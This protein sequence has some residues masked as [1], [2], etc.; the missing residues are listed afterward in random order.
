MP[1]ALRWSQEGGIIPYERG[2]SVHGPQ[3]Y[4]LVEPLR[5]AQSTYMCV[6][7]PSAGPRSVQAGPL[8]LEH[9]MPFRSFRFFELLT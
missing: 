6:S 8:R 1:R 9:A 5:G 2:T 7:S 4:Q 3:W